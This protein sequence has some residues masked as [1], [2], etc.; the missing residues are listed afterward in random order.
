MTRIKY[1]RVSYTGAKPKRVK[2]QNQETLGIDFLTYQIDRP[3]F[4]TEVQGFKEYFEAAVT[5]VSISLA[6]SGV[7][8]AKKTLLNAETPWGQARMRGEYFGVNF[9]PYGKGPGRFDTGN[10]YNSLKILEAPTSFRFPKSRHQIQV[11]FGYDPKMDRSPKWGGPYFLAQERGFVNPFSFRPDE[12]R[13]SG[14]A[15]FGRSRSPRRVPG[16]RAMEAASESVRKRI[17]SALSAALNEAKIAFESDGFASAGVGRYIDGRDA[18]R[19]SPQRRA[20]VGTGDYDVR[21]ATYDIKNRIN[22]PGS[23]GGGSFLNMRTGEIFGNF[24]I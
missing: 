20:S 4:F 19:S 7:S 16:A 9:R 15:T 21:S 24:K 17:D 1:S 3:Q 18:F 22:N 5:A 6:A 11:E 2:L 12:T 10:M 13:A 14:V 23:G 8:V